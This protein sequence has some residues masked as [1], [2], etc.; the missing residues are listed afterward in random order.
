MKLTVH[1]AFPT[2]NKSLP[3]VFRV[4]RSGTA[5]WGGVVTGTSCQATISLS[6]R[7]KSHWPIE[8][9]HKVSVY[10]SSPRG[11]AASRW[12][13]RKEEQ[14]TGETPTTLRR[15][16]FTVGPRRHRP[17]GSFFFS[18]VRSCSLAGTLLVSHGLIGLDSLQFFQN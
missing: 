13:P 17:L 10:A 11:L 18:E 5:L 6:L 2:D 16:V 15:R 8:D 7:D 4:S 1:L 12:A 9:S 3:S 14:N